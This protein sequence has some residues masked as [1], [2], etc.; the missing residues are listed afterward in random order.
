[1]SKSLFHW[2]VA[3]G[4]LIGVLVLLPGAG[5]A[6]TTR[7]TSPNYTV[8]SVIIG[9]TGV[10]RSSYTGIP[11]F[12]T[13][14]P[15]V[16]EVTTT[17]A[18]IKWSTNKPTNAVVRYGTKPGVY[19]LETGQLTDMSKSSHNIRLNQ[20]VKGNTYYFRARS[21]D[22]AGNV[23]ESAE[24]SFT[25]DAGD[26]IP[27]QLIGK[28]NITFE[29]SAVV[30]VTWLTDELS[31]SIVE[32]GIS[33]VDQYSAGRTDE[34]TTFHR[35]QLTGLQAQ[36]QYLLRVKSRDSEGN[37]LI[38]PTDAITT[39]SN[40][41]ITEVRITDITLN[42]AVVQWKTT[43]PTNSLINYGKTSGA[44]AL[45]AE[46]LSSLTTTHVLR[47][48]GLSTGTPYYI[49][50]SGQDAA[51]NRISSDEYVFQTVVLPIITNF[52]LSEISSN[53]VFLSWN[54]SSDI[55]ELIRFDIIEHVDRALIGK[56]DSKG[57]DILSTKHS[58]TL[59]GLESDA[60][61]RISVSGK[62]V[63]GN[64][65]VSPT[66]EFRTKIDNDP[67]VLE[68]IRTDTT[69]DLGSR[70]TVQV[71]VSFGISE[72]GKALIEY[73]EGASGPYSHKVETDEDFSRN[74]FMVIPGLRP[75]ES[76]HF[77]IVAQDRVGNA[78]QSPDYLVLAP[79]QPVSL[80]DLIFGQI[81]SN[82]GWLGSV[83]R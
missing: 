34:L 16:E 44:Y 68:N 35:V 38:G 5:H 67:P 12:I 77:R 1:M 81:R 50:I 30:T 24:F 14:G 61:Y 59:S 69:V 15:V 78:V 37:Q 4:A 54:S 29:S 75:G 23:V 10:L 9:G 63:Y 19:D 40:P 20:L 83:G 7:F 64:R 27:P 56:Q 76:Y 43:I 60:R 58:L 3:A 53:S 80:F 31:N 41:S 45:K 52:T 51:N 65:A 21:A 82:F 17:T 28:V 33:Q 32:Y 70:Q 6:A 49:R 8:E 46:D 55:D 72:P 13:A 11:P 57:N 47:L 73:G 71:L 79:A 25:T 2:R 66:L 39:L 26:V 42:S 36:Q 62:D 18:Q 48:D 74:K 22:I